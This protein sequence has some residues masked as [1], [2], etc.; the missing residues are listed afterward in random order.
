MWSRS[1]ILFALLSAMALSGCSDPAP[2]AETGDAD[3]DGVCDPDDLC[4]E[5]NDGDDFDGDGVPDGCDPCPVDAP[6]DS[7]ADG[8]CDSADA[9][10]GG[11]DAMDA[12]SDGTA[13]ACDP[14]P[15]DASDDSDGDGVCDSADLCAGFDDEADLDLD[16]V[17]D[18]CD[19]CP[20]DAL[21]DQDGDTVCDSQDLCPGDDDRLDGDSDGTPDGC[22]ICPSDATDDS[23]GD[24]VCDSADLCAGFDDEADL[25]RDGVAD[26]CDP[27][28]IDAP[29]D[30][31]GDGVCASA[32]LCDDQW[33][34]NQEDICGI[35]FV[36][37]T[38]SGAGDG[39]SWADAFTEIQDAL[40]PGRTVWVAQGVYRGRAGEPFLIDAPNAVQIYG[41]FQGGEMRL[42]DRVGLFAATVLD[43]DLNG[44]DDGSPATVGDNVRG[45]NL[46]NNVLI[47]GFTV[48]HADGANGAAVHM[49]SSWNAHVR[50]L[51]VRDSLLTAN[52]TLMRCYNAS[53]EYEHVL[54]VDNML[55]GRDVFASI[56]F[57]DQKLTNVTVVNTTGAAAAFA[58]SGQGSLEVRYSS[59]EGSSNFVYADGSAIVSDSVFYGAGSISGTGSISIDSTAASLDLSTYGSGN[60]WLDDG[61]A[62]LGDPWVVFAGGEL[63]LSQTDAGD[64][65]T[66]AAVDAADA[67]FDW[68]R[69]PDWSALTTAADLG[70]D[71]TTADM[72]AHYDPDRPFI[73]ELYDDGQDLFWTTLNA[74]DCRLNGAAVAANGSEPASS[75]RHVLYCSNAS[76]DTAASHAVP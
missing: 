23:D 20:I 51:I 41:G 27:C 19:P 40:A 48:R 9:C 22:D 44:D 73:V 69:L 29:D 36:D 6:D 2:C 47:D 1:A 57:C 46:N 35:V 52:T 39:S 66:S 74:T 8:V 17:A 68:S 13:D 63:M 53:V 10:P 25:D 43:A 26:G 32:D 59:V 18:G 31:D 49:Y 62:E 16:G 56:G 3:A 15:A 24:G 50:N 37:A 34:P 14:C 54:L 21:N 11:D 4:A 12:D 28:P 58:C 76:G 72:G 65:F 45:I 75:G 5:G 55:G 70:L 60:L 61:T 38:A 30:A 71:I 42:E 67:A 33:N 64:P 7:D